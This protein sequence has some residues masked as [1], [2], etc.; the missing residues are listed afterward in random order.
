MTKTRIR[1]DAF[2]QSLHW[3]I[4]LG[5]VGSYAIGL[6]REGLPKTDFRAFLLQL[7]MW[8]GML[9]MALSVVRIGWR[10]VAPKVAS[11]QG[12]SR[13]TK[14]AAKLVHLGLYA[15]ML[16]IPV[17]GLVSAWI[18][19]RTVGFFGL[20]LP[21]PFAVDKALGGRIEDLHELAAHAMMA[22]AG[23]HAAAA[24]GHQYILRDGTLGRMLPLVSATPSPNDDF[25]GAYP[26]R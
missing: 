24:I 20:P 14:L 26:A 13:Q 7:H 11:V 1:H 3:L 9:V 23:L 6:A 4:V 18:K 5:V 19:G 22:L 8:I 2:T 21:S 15:A 25:P 10:S 16:A 17:I 12:M